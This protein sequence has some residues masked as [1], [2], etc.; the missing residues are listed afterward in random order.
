MND[1]LYYLAEKKYT[2]WQRLYKF[3][4]QAYTKD[5]CYE[6]MIT[7]AKYENLLEVMDQLSLNETLKLREIER[8]YFSDVPYVVKG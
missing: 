5:E 3:Q 2:M 4:A 1:F 6:R 7:I 8:E